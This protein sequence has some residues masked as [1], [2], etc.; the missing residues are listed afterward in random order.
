MHTRT[1][2]RARRAAAS[3]RGAVLLLFGLFVFAFLALAALVLDLGIARLTQARMQSAAESVAVATLQGRDRPWIPEADGP[4]PEVAA[5]RD[6]ERRERARWLATWAFRDVVGGGEGGPGALEVGGPGPVASVTGAVGNLAAGGVLSA[7][8][9]TEPR[10]ATN[11][12]PPDPAGGVPPT[13]LNARE[14]DI[15]AGSFEPV[16]TGASG[17]RDIENSS[18]YE[19]ADFE[20][21]APQEAA[22][23]DAVLVRLRRTRTGTELDVP[24]DQ[25]EHVSTSGPT[26]PLLF[27]RGAPIRGDATHGGPNPRRTGIS[28]R[29]TAI[30]RAA[31]ALRV[32]PR[33]SESQIQGWL[34]EG[35]INA[36]QAEVLRLGLA[37]FGWRDAY[38]FDVAETASGFPFWSSDGTARISLRAVEDP[39]TGTVVF[40]LFWANS[41]GTEDSG[42]EV[43]ACFSARVV[44]VGDRLLDGGW[45]CPSGEVD[46]PGP[47]IP[48]DDADSWAAAHLAGGGYPQFWSAYFN[49][50]QALMPVFWLKWA[51]G[52]GVQQYVTGFVRV[53]IEVDPS[54]VNDQ[55]I[56]LLTVTKLPNEQA[57]GRPWVAPANASAVFDGLQAELDELPPAG[58]YSSPW[59]P[60]L[61]GDPAA[62]NDFNQDG[63]EDP[64][65]RYLWGLRYL[66][67][68]SLDTVVFAPTLAR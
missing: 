30:A 53:A 14:G 61:E 51:P 62:Y 17:P 8:T 66:V 64:G 35:R 1:D 11:Y 9:R 6:F 12:L 2:T 54:L 15:V 32:G 27:G 22:R 50:S 29:G 24:L 56:P 26:L 31:P 46:P 21:A 36:E 10:L 67:R 37:P 44:R 40:K 25:V 7:V 34:D 55:G 63:Q 47:P 65:E 42:T 48:C 52:L 41:S 58:P 49:R 43:G 4:D 45:W 60:I 23:A 20:A 57:P 13:P 39:A 68:D 28:V 19:R 16:P 18:S 33:L 5:R 38:W 3:R 59:I